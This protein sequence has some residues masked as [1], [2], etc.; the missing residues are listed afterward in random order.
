MNPTRTIFSTVSTGSTAFAGVLAAAVTLGSV[1]MLFES[2]AQA[3]ASQIV[4][5]S[6]EAAHG[7][8]RTAEPARQAGTEPQPVQVA[9]LD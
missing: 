4:E 1:A 6:S 8:T 9:T 5:R 2:V 7:V 3:P